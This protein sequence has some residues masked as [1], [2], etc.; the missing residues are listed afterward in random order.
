MDR[1]ERHASCPALVPSSLVRRGGDR[2]RAEARIKS[3][4]HCAYR[5]P[6]GFF[7]LQRR[8]FAPL[9]DTRYTA[10]SLLVPVHRARHGAV[11]LPRAAARYADNG[12]YT[13]QLYVQGSLLGPYGVRAK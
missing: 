3:L 12:L 13:L 6:A 10:G 2:C 9:H 7:L 11:A 8:R 4:C 5:L 1:V